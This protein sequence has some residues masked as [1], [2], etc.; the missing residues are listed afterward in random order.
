MCDAPF[1]TASSNRLSRGHVQFSDLFVAG[2]GRM[3]YFLPTTK[4]HVDIDKIRV[5][6][7]NSFLEAG[8]KLVTR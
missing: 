2:V 5:P 8:Y 7:R 4:S 1:P 3:S 6:R